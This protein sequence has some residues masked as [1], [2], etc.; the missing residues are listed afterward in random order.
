MLLFLF[1]MFIVIYYIYIISTFTC[2]EYKTKKDF[3][4]DL[5]PCHAI[6]RYFRN[7]YEELI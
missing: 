4:K 2:G 5:I 6:Y 7:K 1:I 3:R